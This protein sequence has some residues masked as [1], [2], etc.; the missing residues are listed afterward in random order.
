MTR[1]IACA[2]SIAMLVVTLNAQTPDRSTGADLI[3]FNGHITTQNLAQPEASALAVKRGRIFSV[4][5]DAEILS[6][7][8]S[9][10]RLIDAEGKRLIPGLLDAHVHVLN[11]KA[12]NYNVRWDGVPTL[13]RALEMLREQGL[14]TPDGQWVKVIG[15]WS[16][17]QFKEH[18]LPTMEEL[19]T[20]VPNRPLIVQYAYNQ[21]FLNDLAM[22]ALGVGTARFP[23]FPGTVFEKDQNGRETGVVH[24]Y[25][26][27]FGT[28]EGMVPQPSLEEQVSSLT[29]VIN[30]LNRFGITSV[31][32]G[33]GTSGYPD[34]HEAL[35]ALIRKGRLNIRFTFIDLQFGDATGRSVVDADIDAITKKSPISPGDNIHPTMVHGHEYEG[36][37]ELLRVELHDHE[38]FDRPAVIIDKATMRRDIEEDVTKLVQRRIPFRMHI[39]YDE[40]ITPFLDALEQVNQHTP[41]DGL[42]WSI[43]H[44]ETISPENIARVKALGGGIALDDKM[45]LHG[46][47]FAKTYSR[48]K[49]LQTPPLR[50]LVDSGVPVAMT[51]DGFRASS[52]N[53]WIGIRWMVSGKSV[54]GT[55]G[56]ARDNRVS[57]EEALKLWTLGAAW[58]MH[59]ENE[60]GRIAPGNL[61]D[62]S[63]LSADYFSV[64]EGEI[65][66][67]SSVLTVVGGRVV[68]G[69]GKYGTLAPTLPE[70]IP[71]WSPVKYFG[72]FYN[73]K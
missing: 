62:F 71:E 51:T 36:A 3:V 14:R 21:A 2:I 23:M 30:D 16:P 64:P 4:G 39:S 19:T 20:A 9:S 66:N 18:R 15:G 11:E 46:E 29:Y 53:P 5:N 13:K 24:G 68:F 72:N 35:E 63:L 33:G 54:S 55:E 61:A 49:A 6:L 7:K 70:P 44:A 25:T 50:R 69:T 28:M 58:F 32:D 12:N 60:M 37:G 31:I 22:K 27:T 52:Y 57:R 41:L 43:E 17:Y 73:A 45:A 1:R 38:N 59:A 47:A 8:G 56:L 40:N 26:F 67:I 42:R 48:E 65:A 10:T 34:G